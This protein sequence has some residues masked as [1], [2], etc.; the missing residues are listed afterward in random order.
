MTP[1]SPPHAAVKAAADTD[2]P[3]TPQPPAANR[4]HHHRAERQHCRR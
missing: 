4:A 1:V 3:A 2:R